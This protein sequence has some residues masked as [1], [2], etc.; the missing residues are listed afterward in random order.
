MKRFLA[1]LI[2]L[3]SAILIIGFAIANRNWVDVSLDPFDRTN[4]AFALHLPLWAVAILG[5]FIGVVAGWIAAWLKQ[6]RWRRLARELKAENSVLRS[7]NAR[8]EKESQPRARYHG[9]AKALPRRSVGCVSSAARRSPR[10]RP[11]GK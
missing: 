3:P 10:R 5:L 11:T 6:G 9:A 7:E 8:L 4:P 2:G 1:W